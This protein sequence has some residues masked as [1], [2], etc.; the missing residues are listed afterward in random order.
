MSEYRGIEYLRKKLNSKRSRVLQRYKFY[1]MK[2]KAK[3]YGLTMPPKMNWMNSTLGWCAKSVDS[4][5]DRLIFREFKDDNFGLMTIFQM[6]NPDTFFDSAILSAL[7]SSCCFVYISE[8]EYGF[9][10][11]QVIDG[12]NA[13]GII[14]PITNLLTEGYAVL[15]RDDNNK[16]TLEAYF[17]SGQ[18]EIIRKGDGST[19]IFLNDA[20]YPLLVP[21]VNRPDAVRPFG[22][23]RISRA[24]MQ[25]VESAMRTIKRSEVSAEFYSFPQKYVIGLSQEAEPIEKWKA[26]MSS[27]LLFT[28]DDDGDSPKVGQFTQQSMSPYTEQLRTFAAMFAGEN[29]LTLDDLG[30]LS[31]NPSSAEAIKASH[32]NLRL[33]A[34]KAQRIFGSCFLNVGYL[35][36]CVRDNYNYKRKQFYLTSPIWEPIFEPDAATLSTIGDGA[37]KINQAIPGYFNIDNLRDLTGI[38]NSDI[39]FNIPDSESQK[40]V[41]TSTNKRV[42]TYEITS[43]L[44]KRNKG[45]LTYNN[46]VRLLE[47]L[48]LSENEARQILDDKDI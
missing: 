38:K 16:P 29:G 14:D 27:M 32:E 20:P 10:R 8:D 25:I 4:L 36:A 6:N 47:K 45:L 44:E 21:I 24:N 3:D 33:T 7:I 34:R 5:A 37:I 39:E 22:H 28:K 31:D 41:T 15:D 46:T 11:L 9:P 2:N 19:E 43:I 12:A 23:S 30:F 1:E 26:T 17:V 48:G 13:T 18:T 42:S 35:A 40:S